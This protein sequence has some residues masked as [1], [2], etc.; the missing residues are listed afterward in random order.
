M[1][2]RVYLKLTLLFLSTLVALGV[3]EAFCRIAVLTGDSLPV[4]FV[5][6]PEINYRL[7]PGSTGRSIRGIDYSI[8]SDGLRDR[9]YSSVEK[10]IF[11]VGD[12][13]TFGYGVAQEHTFGHLL[14]E[15][16]GREVLNLG[17]IGYRTA[18]S[19]IMLARVVK[20][21]DP[22]IIVALITTTTMGS[23]PTPGVVKDG[24][25]L[26]REN[27]PV[28]L[29]KILRPF[30][31]Y[32]AV[33]Q[34]SVGLGDKFVRGKQAYRVPTSEALEKEWAGYLPHLQRLVD[35]ARAYD[36]RLVLGY[37][38]YRGHIQYGHDHPLRERVAYFARRHSLPLVDFTDAFAAYQEDLD[39]VILK[40]DPCHPNKHGHRIL[41]D[42]FAE[43]LQPLVPQRKREDPVESL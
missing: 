25:L 26:S 41:A 12:S 10:K 28:R 35:L 6:D 13:N 23:E 22:D 7:K 29:K 42:G 21:Y 37:L 9:E 43:V 4:E 8:N 34:A 31:L 20:E 32:Y 3:A 40:M 39:A 5:A 14:E 19:N 36:A 15:R 2:K 30:A 17:L 16:L 1:I 33:A 38:P 27:F 18:S 11:L 24:L